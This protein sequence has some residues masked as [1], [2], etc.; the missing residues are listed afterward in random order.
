MFWIKIDFYRLIWLNK[1]IKNICDF[2]Y[3]PN[4]EKWFRPKI[5]FKKM[6]FLKSFYDGNHFTSKQTEHKTLFNFQ[7][8]LIQ[9]IKLFR[10]KEA[11][12]GVFY[13]FL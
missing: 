6:T 4:T 2:P 10:Y 9:I 3:V 8:K 13:E 7:I 11:K 5:F 12:I 1:N